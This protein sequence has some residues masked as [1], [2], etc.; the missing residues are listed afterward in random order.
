MKAF[1]APVFLCLFFSSAPA[2]Y[3][4]Q[5]LMPH[6]VTVSQNLVIVTLDGVRWQDVF[7]GCDSSLVNDPSFNEDTSL[8]KLLYWSARQEDRRKK[9]MPFFWN[10]LVNKGQLIGNRE[11]GNN[12]NIANSYGISYPGYNEMLTGNTDRQVSS[13]KKRWNENVNVL[14]YLNT[15]EEFN[16]KIAVFTSWNVFPY[17]L[18]TRRNGLKANCGTDSAHSDLLPENQSIFQTSMI[19]EGLNAATRED[20]LTFSAAKYY[21]QKERPRVLFIG[22][23]EADEFAHHGKYDLY[24]D[25]LANYD[26]MLADLWLTIQST[27]TLKNNTTLLITTDHGRGSGPNN[28]SSHN[29]LVKGSFQGWL[30]LIGP[31]IPPAGEQK[32]RND[33]YLEQVAQTIATV[34]G[35][36]FK[37]GDPAPPLALQ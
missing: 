5:Q 28:W 3:S 10:V 25:R 22:L 31:S 19:N 23:G 2:R 21:L 20:R 29:I 26:K 37:I 9:L 32:T 4:P 27:P 12:F 14:E 6:P 34:L 7:K 17:I 1:C 11:F 13:N 24:L 35:Q 8:S 33:Y 15:K 16:Q 18:N 30:G 36:E